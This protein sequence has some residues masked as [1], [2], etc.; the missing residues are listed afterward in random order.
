M[1][2]NLPRV[3][4]QQNPIERSD[5]NF[6][7]LIVGVSATKKLSAEKIPAEDICQNIHFI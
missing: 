1:R 7:M 6:F 4:L 3:K 5:K 2:G